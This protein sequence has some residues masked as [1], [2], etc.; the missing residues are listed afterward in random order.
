MRLHELFY[1]IKQLC[2][3]H[4]QIKS[5]QIGH[6]YDVATSKSSEVYPAV[7]ME[8]PIFTNY[9]DGRKKQ[10]VF[11]LN[12]LT[13]VKSDNIQDV[14][15]KTSDMEAVGDH[16]LQAIKDKY[17][18]IGI[19]NMDGIT[20]RG[21]SDDDLVGIRIELNFMVGRECDFETFFN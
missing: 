3:Q 7:W 19:E 9:I 2:L 15:D 5:V 4:N 11:A 12:F 14:I 21:F 10:H 17:R 8:L 18:K 13:T 6:T 1:E 16:V 20:M